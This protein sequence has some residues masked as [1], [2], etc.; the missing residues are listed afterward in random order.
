LADNTTFKV[1]KYKAFKVEIISTSATYVKVGDTA[2]VS[3]K[4][5]ITGC[6]NPTVLVISDLNASAS[7]GVITVKAPAT[8]GDLESTEAVT[9]MVSN[10]STTVMASV[11]ITVADVVIADASAGGQD[12]LNTA[13]ANSSVSTIL[14]GAGEYTVDLYANA[15]AKTTLNIIGTENTKVK[16]ANKQVRAELYDEL[17]ISNCEILRMATKGWG[18]LVFSTG[19]D[20]GG[21]YTVDN[22]TFNGV[23]SQ[24]VY[25]NEKYS[26]A[27]YNITNCT[28]DGDFGDQGVITIQ[29]NAGVNHTINITGCVFK[30]IPSTSH[31]IYFA[32]PGGGNP[33][34]K[35]TNLHTDNAI[36]ES[37][38]YVKQ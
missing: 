33:A 29:G 18:M 32:S 37:D 11:D 30:N 21:V 4:Y 17:T 19:K 25:I 2:N 1:P 36:A 27:V 13:L 24:G 38:I 14:L 10:G 22:C 5:S 20:T 3:I 35:S 16:F 26:S 23:G 9:L 28:F 34:H 6:N 12:A 31:K 8:R 7:N 15:H